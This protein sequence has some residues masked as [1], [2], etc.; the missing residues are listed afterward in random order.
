V[1]P[2]PEA[3]VSIVKLVEGLDANSAPGVAVPAGDLV[4]F[5]YTVTNTGT[6][7]LESIAVT[8]D[9]GVA[10]T[11]PG[12]ALPPGS[13]M[14]CTGSDTAIEGLYTNVGTVDADGFATSEAVTDDDS[15]NY[16]GV[17]GELTVVKQVNGQDADSA[18][19]AVQ[20]PVGDPVSWT[21]TVTNSG[22]ETV[23]SISVTDDLLGAVTCPETSLDPSESMDCTAINDTADPGLV[24]N[25][26]TAAG[27]GDV[28]SDPVGG[29]DQANYFGQ[30]PAMSVLKEVFDPFTASWLDADADLGTPGSNDPRPAVIPSGSDAQFRFVV[31]N[32][33]NIPITDVAVT[34]PR[35]D[36]APA[37]TGGDAGTPDVLDVGETWTLTCTDSALSGGYTNTATVTGDSAGGTPDGSGTSEA[38]TAQVSELSVAKEVMDP[39]TGEF[40]ESASVP[41]GGDATFRITVTNTGEVPVDD[42]SVADALAPNCERTISGVLEPGESA[43]SYQCT[44]TGVTS[45]FTN[46]ADVSGTPVDGGGDPIG[47][48]VQGS[49]PA[50]VVIAEP[51]DLA[52]TKTLESYDQESGIAEWLVTVTNNGP[53]PAH[54]DI[55]LV[56]NLPTGLEYEGYS[57][58]DWTCSYED[59]SLRCV[60]STFMAE[61]E[62]S[63]IS[64]TTTVD[65]EAIDGSAVNSATVS[66]TGSDSDMSNNS[67]D[68]ALTTEQPGEPAG[69]PAGDPDPLPRTGGDFGRL[70]V[71]ALGLIAG[72]WLAVRRSRRHP[73]L[74]S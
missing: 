50:D 32:T 12:T 71:L 41:S 9:Q 3:G 38:A 13:S 37:V 34:D 40:G 29:S 48:P 60:R 33:G 16:T 14:D 58:A 44:L 70:I 57:A 73:A 66:G 19:T 31:A 72:G 39:I 1:L 26:A 45:G 10:V 63:E 18:L 68:D 22:T 36:A 35:C 61:G 27:T 42:I 74:S 28:S 2:V 11:C 7:P 23:S 47:D 49:D 65:E 69:D 52:V 30:Q 6:E 62:S 64:I 21:F 55:T 59:P 56:D 8:D 43:A 20:L 4:D 54:P 51:V 67:D 24:T 53:G 15:A 5:T 17:V 25:L 46:V